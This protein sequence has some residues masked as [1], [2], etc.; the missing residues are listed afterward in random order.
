[1]FQYFR[2]SIG[3]RSKS[4]QLSLKFVR[5]GILNTIFGLAIYPALLLVFDEL[6]HHFMIGL[7]IAQIFSICFAFTIYKLTVFKNKSGVFHEFLRFVPFYFFNYAIN[8]A[9]LPVLVNIVLINPI[10][11]QSGFSLFVIVSSF[12]WHSRVTFKGDYGK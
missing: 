3:H 8:W 7:I 1:M 10:I 6:K 4:E 11:A 12:F 2:E 5:A 9:V